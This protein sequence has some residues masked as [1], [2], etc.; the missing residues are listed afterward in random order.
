[1]VDTKASSDKVSADSLV[2][3]QLVVVRCLFSE[4]QRVEF[5]A[6]QAYNGWAIYAQIHTLNGASEINDITYL[7]DKKLVDQDLTQ[8]EITTTLNKL[9]NIDLL[10]ILV[11]C[12]AWD[13]NQYYGYEQGEFAKFCKGFLKEY[14]TS[15]FVEKLK[16]LLTFRC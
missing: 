11:K 12:R 5:I 15:S 7:V 9:K 13:N 16:L 6:A 1:M 10:Q 14:K 3:D 2:L 4:N 8:E